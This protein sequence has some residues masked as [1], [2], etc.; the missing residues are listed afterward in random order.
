MT[1]DEISFHDSTIGLF[2]IDYLNSEIT[3]D[4]IE[5]ESLSKYRVILKPFKTFSITNNI[6]WGPSISINELIDKII[7]AVSWF[8]QC[9]SSPLALCIDK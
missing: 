8:P 6:P 4:I 5:S 3:F 1:L 2:S 9:V 7:S